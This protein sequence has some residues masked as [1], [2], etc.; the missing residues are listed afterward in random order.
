[1]IPPLRDMDGGVIAVVAPAKINLYLHVI[2]RRDDGYHLLDSL[3]AFAGL[4]DRIMIEAAPGLSLTVTGPFAAAVPVGS[5]N[6]V[7]AAASALA[8]AAGVGAD[9]AII[10]D[11]H[12]PAG[13]GMGG[14]SA[15]AAA[16]LRALAHLWGLGAADAD[17]LAVAAGLGA[18][19]PMCLAGRAAF[20]GGIGEVLAPAPP[21]PEAGLVLVNPGIPLATPAVFAARSGDF[22]APAR[23]DEAPGDAAD[24]ADLLAVRGNDLTAAA[25]A[26]VP[27][28]ADVLA[29]LETAPGA[30]LTRMTGSGAT[31]FALFDDAAAAATASK[32]IAARHP[33]WWCRA[34]NLEAEF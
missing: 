25:T 1:V 22:G 6:L 15:D 19:V 21:L 10:L 3:I 29:A 17:L 2:C 14:G 34:T 11:K 18:D 27:A 26:L 7:L 8:E 24:L 13:A 33:D 23:F 20:V 9:A 5:D 4:G 31:C 16:T 28:I 12:L 30:R 32:D